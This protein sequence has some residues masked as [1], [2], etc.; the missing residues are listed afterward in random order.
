MLRRVSSLSTNRT[1]SR[2]LVYD[3]HGDPRQ[4]M[5]I[6]DFAIHE[7][8]ADELLV[9]VQMAPINPSDL[10]QIEGVYPRRPPLPGA[11]GGNEGVMRVLQVGQSMQSKWSVG[12]CA[13]P[14]S[15]CFGTWR[16]RAVARGDQLV[17]V[18][19][20]LTD[21]QASTMSVNV[22]S[23]YRMLKDFPIVDG[24]AVIVNAGGSGVSRAAVQ[25]CRLW[26][27]PCVA[28]VRDRPAIE[29]LRA[30]LMELG[31]DLVVTQESISSSDKRVRDDIKSVA[32]HGVSLALN[33]VGGRAAMD[34][35]RLLNTKGTMVTYGAMSKK[36]TP[37]PASVQ[38]F[39]DIALRGFWMAQW[40]DDHPLAEY[41]EMLRDIEQLYITGKLREPK[42]D[43]VEW[44]P[45]TMDSEELL[46]KFTNAI[47]SDGSHHG[48][49]VLKMRP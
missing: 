31:A 49:K 24:S 1:G 33:C 38:I 5:R 39:K 19:S 27:I 30:E 37:V 2:A 9:Q 23:A 41:L 11:V 13:I 26:S 6:Q 4:V 16:S 17:K 35:L 45:E 29:E 25:L 8:R 18:S 47:S 14:H 32:P 40:K 42:V 3:S 21:V 20:R 34:L 44:F 7:P 28:V 48:K 36:P 12:D 43:V 22:F 15:A 46:Q 10:N